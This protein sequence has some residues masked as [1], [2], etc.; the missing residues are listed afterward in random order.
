M[1]V[2]QSLHVL[3]DQ[4]VVCVRLWYGLQDSIVSESAKG[5]WLHI[6]LL[7]VLRHR[8]VR[9]ALHIDQHECTSTP[10]AQHG[11]RKGTIGDRLACQN[12]LILRSRKYHEQEATRPSLPTPIKLEDLPAS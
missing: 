1:Q 7:T 3:D 10:Q 9:H 6:Q 11:W 5:T 4:Q 12:V 8:H 2:E